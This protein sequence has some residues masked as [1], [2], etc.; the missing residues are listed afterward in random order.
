MEAFLVKAVILM[1]IF[2][3]CLIWVAR[4]TAPKG[5]HQ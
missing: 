5:K 1:I 4:D 2:I 3:A